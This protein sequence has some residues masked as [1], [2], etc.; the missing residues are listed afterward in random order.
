MFKEILASVLCI[1]IVGGGLFLYVTK[2]WVSVD[3]KF[4]KGECLMIDAD[5]VETWFDNIIARV[6]TVGKN[7]YGVKYWFEYG[8]SSGTGTWPF[9]LKSMK[10]E[11]PVEPKEVMNDGAR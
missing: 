8:W 10:V 1:M 9:S 4:N 7:N 11:C 2:P 6:E 5:G 3:M